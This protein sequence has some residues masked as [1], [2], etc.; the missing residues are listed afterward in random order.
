MRQ[1]LARRNEP[2]GRLAIEQPILN[3]DS[4]LKSRDGLLVLA[5]ISQYI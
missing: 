1:V 4:A 3:L 2:I 5:Q